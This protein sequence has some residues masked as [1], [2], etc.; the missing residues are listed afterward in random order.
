MKRN[1]FLFVFATLQAILISCNSNPT[2][3]PFEPYNPDF[4]WTAD[5]IA[6]PNEFQTIMYSI[7]GNSPTNL[8]MVGHCTASKGVMW[9]YDGN[10]W[11]PVNLF[12]DIAQSSITLYAITGSSGYNMWAVGSRNIG[13][14][15]DQLIAKSLIIR[16]DGFNWNEI[17]NSGT[18]PLR[19]IWMENESS[20]WIGGYTNPINILNNSEHIYKV[21]DSFPYLE[22]YHLAGIGKINDEYVA[23]AERWTDNGHTQVVYDYR[24]KE[25]QDNFVCRDSFVVNSSNWNY[26]WGEYGLLTVNNKL[27]SYGSD[28]VFEWTVN[29]WQ[30]KKETGFNIYGMF[31]LNDK[32]IFAYGDNSLIYFFDGTNWQQINSLQ[33]PGIV[34]WAVWSNGK[35]VF[36]SYC[37]VFSLD[38]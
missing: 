21:R 5:T 15:N 22:G 8:Y 29:K 2:E 3:A 27:F 24:K 6:Y 33:T 7:W 12:K 1:F 34:Y 16:F 11:Q 20:Y 32:E 30:K 38:F 17:T 35:D 25:D 28:G 26:K 4:V 14:E 36:V 19:N 18:S 23:I 13:F 10:S 31:A 9:H 37:L